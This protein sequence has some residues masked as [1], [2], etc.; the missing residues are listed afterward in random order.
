[1]TP[2]QKQIAVAVGT[3]AATA[4]VIVT[5]RRAEAKAAADAEARAKALAAA[6]A[7]AAAAAERAR[8]LSNDPNVTSQYA[9]LET[10]LAGQALIRA[11]EQRIATFTLSLITSSMVFAN[12]ETLRI[13]TAFGGG[14][15][16]PNV[17]DIV[18]SFFYKSDGSWGTDNIVSQS[19]CASR[20]AALSNLNNGWWRHWYETC[21]HTKIVEANGVRY[22]VGIDPQTDPKGYEDAV[23]QCAESALQDALKAASISDV[24]TELGLGSTP[25]YVINMQPVLVKKLATFARDLAEHNEK[26]HAQFPGW[27]A[28]EKAPPAIQEA[29]LTVIH[30]T[31]GAAFIGKI[32]V[33]FTSHDPEL[34]PCIRNFDV[35]DA[36][37]LLATTVGTVLSLGTVSA[38]ASAVSILLKLAQMA[39][40]IGNTLARIALTGKVS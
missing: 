16:Q 22:A 5:V 7:A 20:S 15:G 8:I 17:Y 6:A 27:E 1:M 12:E 21:G 11:H 31:I 37:S 39:A 3:V 14:A 38:A 2:R 10:T 32:A 29:L 34:N 40:S 35:G 26:L 18:M 25:M 13:L 30:A 9:P 28:V 23:Q 19:A 33:N 4:V 24:A 36:F